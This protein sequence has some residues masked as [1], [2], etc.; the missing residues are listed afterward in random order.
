MGN[1][2]GWQT[3][4]GGR[5]LNMSYPLSDVV[6]STHVRFGG[7]EGRILFAIF[8]QFLGQSQFYFITQNPPPLAV[9][10]RHCSAL[11]SWSTGRI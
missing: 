6:T 8:L 10:M 7:R 5:D 11:V 1:C 4:G 2:D 9:L 3:G